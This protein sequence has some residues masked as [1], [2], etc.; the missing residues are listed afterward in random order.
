M[1]VK[2]LTVIVCISLFS[3]SK[4]SNTIPTITPLPTEEGKNTF[5]FKRDGKV[6][7][8]KSKFTGPW[9]EH[10]FHVGPYKANEKY[11]VKL[12]ARDGN[13][14]D[15]HLQILVQ[16]NNETNQ[17][18]KPDLNRVYHI[19]DDYP[20]FYIDYKKGDQED[21]THFLPISEKCTVIFTRY[22]DSIAAGRF[23]YH[24]KNKRGEEI[25]LTEG[26]FDVTLF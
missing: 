17:F 7:V 20:S 21:D 12:T 15:D 11:Y 5:T 2:F 9:D 18:V 3:C 22:D 14:W 6:H 13:T 24:G 26:Q 23:E 16:M 25:S 8:Y 1:K 19:A 4:L 10:G